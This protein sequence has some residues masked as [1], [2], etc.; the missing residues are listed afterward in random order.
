MDDINWD[1]DEELERELARIHARMQ[2]DREYE[3]EMRMAINYEF[4]NQQKIMEDLL[5]RIRS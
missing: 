4:D 5:A 2:V 1:D 3:R